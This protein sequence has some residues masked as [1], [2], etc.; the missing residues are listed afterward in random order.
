MKKQRKH[1]TP[2]EKVAILRQHLLEKE[3]ISKLCDEL[4]LQPT[5]FYRWQKEFFENGASAFEQK[6]RPNNSADQERIAYL[7]K[8]I[9]T[10]DEV[11][12]E[13]MAEHVALKK[14]LENSDWG[15][16]SARHAGPDRGFRPALVGEDGDQRWTVHG[17]ARH[18]RQQIL[19]LARAVRQCERAQ[20]LGFPR[21]L[22]GGLGEAGHHRV[23]SREPPGGL[24]PADV[25]DARRRTSWR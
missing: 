4:G 12:A 19:R 25:H 11:S 7:E 2:D 9:Q 6:A 8:K 21:F 23:S 13:L 3:P 17:V 5:V 20:R 15:L 24:P 22:A 16:R 18:R 1:Y 10:K 14:R